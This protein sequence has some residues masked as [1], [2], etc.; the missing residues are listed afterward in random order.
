G[1]GQEEEEAATLPPLQRGQRR[2]GGLLHA[3]SRGSL[4][5]PVLVRAARMRGTRMRATR[6]R[7]TRT[8]VPATMPGETVVCDLSDLW[9]GRPRLLCTG[10]G[11]RRCHR[12][13]FCGMG[14]WYC[15]YRLSGQSRRVACMAP[16]MNCKPQLLSR[17]LAGHYIG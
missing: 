10:V 5:M 1:A 9:E 17:I 7:A 13:G 14:G 8:R 11:G 15:L 6:M 16:T 3:K 2:N 12:V 4:A